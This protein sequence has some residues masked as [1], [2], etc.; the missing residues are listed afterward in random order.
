MRRAA[1]TK[2]PAPSFTAASAASVVLPK[3]VAAFFTMSSFV[4]NS[5]ACAA[6][7][8]EPLP[9]WA[10]DITQV[11]VCSAYA[12]AGLT[13]LAVGVWF[14]SFWADGATLQF[15]LFDARFKCPL[16]KSLPEACQ[17]TAFCTTDP[18]PGPSTPYAP[19]EEEGP[20]FMDGLKIGLLV[21]AAVSVAIG[22]V[23]ARAAHVRGIHARWVLCFGISSSVHVAV[24][25]V[26]SCSPRRR[27]RVAES[28]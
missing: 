6:S 14:R 17:S 24:P 2:S 13:K 3:A 1:P 25:C 8:G 7:S 10:V 4:C 18:L 28:R 5:H 20:G 19:E 15:Y 21:M 9:S 26:D 11:Y 22:C 27:S 23:G 16:P 12:G